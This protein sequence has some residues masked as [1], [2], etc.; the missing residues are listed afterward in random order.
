MI[1]TLRYKRRSKKMLD[2]LSSS[3]SRDRL[4]SDFWTKNSTRG[5]KRKAYNTAVQDARP[6]K[7]RDM[8]PAKGT[9]YANKYLESL[10]LI[11]NGFL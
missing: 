8:N 6:L 11:A 1:G 4:Y 9:V 10:I 5:M 3:S 7:K 2:F